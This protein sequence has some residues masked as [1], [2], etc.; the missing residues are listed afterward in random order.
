MS[1]WRGKRVMSHISPFFPLLVPILCLFNLFV[2]WE[3]GNWV[4]DE[5]L[6][7]NEAD[8][9]VRLLLFLHHSTLWFLVYNLF[10]FWSVFQPK[11]RMDKRVVVGGD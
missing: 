2:F 9:F 10:S 1:V 5:L 4:S 8:I 3:V 6:R 11:G 7:L